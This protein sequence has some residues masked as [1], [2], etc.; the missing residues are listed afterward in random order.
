LHRIFG[1]A[2][3]ENDPKTVIIAYTL[4][5]RFNTHL[6]KHSA[7]STYH[8]LKLYCTV[9]NCPILAETHQYTEA[10]T[11]ILFHPKLKDLLVNTNMTVY[12][13]VTVKDDTLVDDYREGAIIIT[14]TFLST[15]ESREVAEF[16]A[17]NEISIIF[18]Y[19]IHGTCR[20]TALRIKE[21]SQFPYEEEVLILRYVPFKVTSI[22]RMEEERQIEI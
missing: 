11:N 19:H 10:F 5:Q 7:A 6:H 17:P 4:L 13:G 8:S 21:L 18:T 16:Y 1:K 15:S 2:R 20:R 22:T 9:L 3:K 12:C 14:T